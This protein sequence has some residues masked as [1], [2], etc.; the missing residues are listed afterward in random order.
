M[1]LSLLALE[2]VPS[3]KL[4]VRGMVDVGTLRL[5]PLFLDG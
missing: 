5:V 1:L 3:L 4:T 2:V